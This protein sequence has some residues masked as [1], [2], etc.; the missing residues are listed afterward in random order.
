MSAIPVLGLALILGAPVPKEAKKPDAPSIVGEW[1]CVEVTYNGR[2]DQPKPGS[3]HRVFKADGEMI[4][5]M[6]DV[7]S[8]SPYSVDPKKDPATLDTG[9]NDGKGS[10][11]LAIYKIEKDT[12]T[13]CLPGPELPGRPAIARKRPV[14][15]DAPAGSR[16]TLMVFKRVEKKE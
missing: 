12:L 7:W 8:R 11:E 5:H 16:L 14:T 4:C 13:L 1:T 9:T 3:L 2:T 10:L 6:D 15:F